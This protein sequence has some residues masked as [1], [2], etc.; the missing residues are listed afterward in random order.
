MIGT[1]IPHATITDIYDKQITLKPGMIIRDRSE[2]SYTII[3][4]ISKDDMG[5][6]LIWGVW[7][8]NLELVKRESI[9][10]SRLS[11]GTTDGMLIQII[12]DTGIHKNIRELIREL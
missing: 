7:D 6:I 3:K 9:K 12:D 5:R 11:F 10:K 8:E 4:T 2:E 1:E